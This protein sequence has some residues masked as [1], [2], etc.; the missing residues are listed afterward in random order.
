MTEIIN[1][2]RDTLRKLQLK[3]LE[4]LVYFDKFCR[5]ND[6]RYYLLGGCVIGAIRHGG[7]I[8]WD[9]DIDLIMPRADYQKMLKLWRQQ[10]REN[11]RYLMLTT[12][13]RRVFTG[14]CFATMVDTSATMI[15]ENQK[16]IDVPHGIVT[17]IFPMDG[18]PEGK[19][20]R[21]L[22]YYHAM[23]YSLYITE[24]VPQN[25][26]GVVR[27]FGGLLLKLVPDRKRRTRIWKKHEKK[28]SKY[29]FETHE[30][31]TELCAGPHYM[32]NKYPRDAFIKAEYHE[33][34]G[35]SMPLPT[36]YDVYLKTAF[37]DYMALPPED[38]QAPHHDLVGLDLNK[39]CQ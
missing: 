9:D 25:H 29:D 8:P 18:C 28:M 37:G 35:L 15:K 36:G 17:D 4:S 34:E 24:V 31:C 32:L 11:E 10:E 30:F 14:N 5:R 20:K 19:L 2:D 1:V 21:Y 6:L 3:E 23:M 22:Q 38:K 7:F 13:G 12:D 33:F 39:P 26:G 27:F 16:D